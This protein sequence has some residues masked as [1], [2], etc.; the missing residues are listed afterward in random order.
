[1][2]S[3]GDT[4]KERAEARKKYVKREEIEI[5]G[6]IGSKRRKDKEEEESAGEETVEER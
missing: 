2:G 3:G 1:M 4:E 6:N 5:G